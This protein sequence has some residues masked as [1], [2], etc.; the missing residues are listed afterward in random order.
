[1]APRRSPAA[2]LTWA[3]PEVYFLQPR[4]N[5][6]D[7]ALKAPPYDSMVTSSLMREPCAQAKLTA[8]PIRMQ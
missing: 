2:D 3:Y 5:L 7:T 6:S 4:V 1:M 8:V